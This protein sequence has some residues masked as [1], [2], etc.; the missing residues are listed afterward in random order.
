MRRLL[1][2]FVTLLSA[3]CFANQPSTLFKPRSPFSFDPWFYYGDY[4]GRRISESGKIN[5][6]LRLLQM[7]SASPFMPFIIVGGDFITIVRYPKR[8]NKPLYLFDDLSAELE[9][10]RV[11]ALIN[12][13][14]YLFFES[15]YQVNS[16]L[17]LDAFFTFGNLNES[18]IYVT[19]GKQYLPYGDFNHYD[20]EAN[21]LTKTIFRLNQNAITFGLKFNDLH[22]K[23]IAGLEHSRIAGA[24]EKTSH[25]QKTTLTQGVGLI[26]NIVDGTRALRALRPVAKGHVSAIDYYAIYHIRPMQFRFEVDSALNRLENIK[27]FT[28]YD[29]E[30]QYRFSL[31][32]RPSKFILSTSG[33]LNANQLNQNPHFNALGIFTRQYVVS[34]KHQLI[35]HVTMGMAAIYGKRINYEKQIV[36]NLVV[37]A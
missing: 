32:N 20:V 19:A 17:V 15:N 2:V 28:A 9:N 14:R 33:L 11:N 3:T 25:L 27:H 34:F 35:K 31:L 5:R 21:P 12:I 18:P 16:D 30:G 22:I 29:L 36:V 6:D 13:N 23:L 1:A 26:N 7:K 24:I 10:L 8:D 4:G 37:K